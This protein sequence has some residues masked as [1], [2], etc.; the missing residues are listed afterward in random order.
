MDLTDFARAADAL[1]TFPS[2]SPPPIHKVA[3][4]VIGI[5][6][7]EPLL[8]PEFPQICAMFASII[9]DRKH[10]GLWTGLHWQHTT[11]ADIIREVFGYVNNNTHDGIVRHSPILVAIQDV[12]KD[13]KE[14]RKLIDNCWLQK[15]WS[16]T[17]TPK[18]FFF[19]EVAGAMD[20]LF[21]GPGGLPVTPECWQAPISAFEDQIQRWC[22]RCG[23]PLNLL[24]RI[25]KENTD[26]ITPSNLAILQESPRVKDGHYVTYEGLP[27]STDPWRYMR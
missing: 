22:Y 10:R 7:G 8:H 16:G 13:P 5:I 3:N 12:I 15:T 27:K 2:G 26:D 9:P 18:G 1:S 17:I 24:G 4:K 14:Q 11:H 25:D 21:D 20:M 23:V 6:G 19:C